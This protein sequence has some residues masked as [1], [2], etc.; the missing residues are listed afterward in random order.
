MTKSLL[1]YRDLKQKYQFVLQNLSRWTNESN[2][3]LY[4]EL[5]NNVKCSK[6]NILNIARFRT[7]Y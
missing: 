6:V 1:D 3:Q 2:D 4:T 7:D 5:K